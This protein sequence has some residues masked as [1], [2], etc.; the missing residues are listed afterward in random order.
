MKLIF[1]IYP[2]PTAALKEA[3]CP[4]TI[5]AIPSPFEFEQVR[6]KLANSTTT[7]RRNRKAKI[8]REQNLELN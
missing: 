3:V 5:A 7:K 6:F 8:F 2:R 4:V 1:G